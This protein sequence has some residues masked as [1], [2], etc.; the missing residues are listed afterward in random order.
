MNIRKRL[1]AGVICLSMAAALPLTEAE[2]AKSPTTAPPA[3]E[4]QIVE[5]IKK[6]TAKKEGKITRKCKIC[7]RVVETLA[8]P[9]KALVINPGKKKR[10]ISNALGCKFKLVNPAKYKKYFRL[11]KKTGNIRAIKNYSV[12][13]KKSIP[14]KVTVGGKAYT[15]KVR[16]QI[17]KP[18]VTVKKQKITIDGVNGYR[19]AFS[20]NLK[21]ATRIKVRVQGVKS[22]NRACDMYISKPKSDSE[23]YLNLRE[24][25]VKKLGNKVT[26]KIIA[27]YGENASVTRVVSK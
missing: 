4:H 19:Y 11:N 17:P 26:F 2:A 24:E 8:L 6:P 15:V 22:L 13:F 25:T 3:H 10:V 18:K 12:K 14:V 23:S 27:Y 5:E 1:L 16:I 20:Y 7:G 9:R 21:D